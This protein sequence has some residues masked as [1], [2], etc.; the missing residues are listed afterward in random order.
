M[1]AKIIHQIWNERKQ[2]AWLFLE[3]AVASIFLWL[4]IDPLF[5]LVCRNNIPKGYD[6]ENLHYIEK[7]I[8]ADNHPQYHDG[9]STEEYVEQFFTNIINTL[10]SLPEVECYGIAC[11]NFQPNDLSSNAG[12]IRIDS[13]QSSDGK[14]HT[15]NARFYSFMPTEG[16]NFFET[17]R[18]RDAL[19][20]E[21]MK[22]M[23]GVQEKK[24]YVT[25][26]LAMQLFGT[27]DIIG[28][29]VI[30]YNA[31]VEIIGIIE[32]MQLLAYDEYTPFMLRNE[33]IIYDKYAFSR[34]DIF[35]RLKKGVDCEAFRKKF[36]SDIAPKLR[37]GNYNVKGITDINE[38]VKRHDKRFGITNIYRLY[39]ALAGFAL[40]CA[41][42]GVFSAFWIRT[43]NRRRDIGIMRSVGASR[44]AVVQQFA[45]EA[46][47]LV[48]VAFLV[49]MF[50]TG[51]Y[52]HINGFAEPLAKVPTWIQNE[53]P[54]QSYLHN[55]ALPHFAI[56][57]AI[58]YLLVA[59]IAVAGALLPSM[60]ITR[61]LPADALREN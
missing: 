17:Y 57:T 28:K 34:Q 31:E 30:D 39:T 44:R 18:V 1:I 41:F 46:L 6:T 36:N 45:A 27:T 25:R 48:S 50:V 22:Q 29:K 33:N 49:G 37:N 12:G 15:H 47:I 3:L 19:T 21:I 20:G 23:N 53:T 55:R 58:G 40:F 4:A 60:R 35:V 11:T 59:T 54:D 7:E 14:E 52:I 38:R 26:R 16:S 9:E 51:H 56:V 10:K 42:M 13:I 5:T 2:N 32:D 8:Y 24:V 61:S 43:N